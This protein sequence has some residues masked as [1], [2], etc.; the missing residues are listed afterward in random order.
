M[1]L[2][3]LTLRSARLSFKPVALFSEL[4]AA[5][6]D[7]RHECPDQSCG[8]DMISAAQDYTAWASKLSVKLDES[9]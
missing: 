9:S 8:L 2:Q 6:T 1:E 7:K 3:T 5:D 4:A